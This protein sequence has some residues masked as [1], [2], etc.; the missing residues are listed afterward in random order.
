MVCRCGFRF[1]FNCCDSNIGDHMPASCHDVERWMQ[2]A[3]G[4][5]FLCLPSRFFFCFFLDL[6][7]VPAYLSLSDE[8][9]NVNWL[10][11]NTKKCP[12]CHAA[13]EKNGGC[14]HMTCRKNAGGCGYEFCWLVHCYSSL[15]LFLSI[16]PPV[17]YLQM[18]VCVCERKLC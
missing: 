7:R 13:I 14:M 1:C 10:L 17:P 2:K 15:F 5:C 3:T 11:A 16:P 9:E 6:S 18:C 12:N 8:S 4:T